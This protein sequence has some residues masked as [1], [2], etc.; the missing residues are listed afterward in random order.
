M[1]AV[2][3]ATGVLR[4]NKL[5][6]QRRIGMTITQSH[7]IM[8]WLVAYSTWMITVGGTGPDGLTAYKRVRHKRSPHASCSWWKWCRSIC[9]P[10][11]PS[12]AGWEP[13]VAVPSLAWCSFTARS[14]TPTS[15][16]RMESCT[17]TGPSIGCRC[18][19]GGLGNS[20]AERRS[21]AKIHTI[22]EAV[23][24]SHSCHQMKSVSTTS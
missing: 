19:S 3:H 13:L 4:T 10:S 12:G 7:P 17:C 5:D 6:L 24:P 9:R 8:N 16:L 15:S 22:R 11:R 21:L 18:P 20:S 1:A 14:P 2:K 23:G